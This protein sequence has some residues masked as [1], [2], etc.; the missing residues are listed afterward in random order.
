[1]SL[2]IKNFKLGSLHLFLLVFLSVLW[3]NFTG[4][5]EKIEKTAVLKKTITHPKVGYKF[6]GLREFIEDVEYIGFYTDRSM[7]DNETAK[8]L[9]QAQYIVAPSILIFNNTDF[10]YILLVCA[11]EKNAWI[12]MKEIKATPIRRNKY[13]IILAQ[14]N[15]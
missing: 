2:K 5:K 7:D 13:G 6:Y 1:M 3:F 8:L 10:E 14:R 11:D 12:K 15:K 4:L 9:S